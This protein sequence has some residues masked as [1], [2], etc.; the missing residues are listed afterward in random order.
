MWRPRLPEPWR[1]WWWQRLSAPLGRPLPQ[2]RLFVLPTRL[3]IGW[4]ALVGVLTLFGINY[5]NSLAY[6]LAFWLAAVGVVGIWR[7]W[8]NLHGVTVQVQPLGEA[9]AGETVRIK[10][11]LR[12][13][14]PRLA[15]QV[16]L[17]EAQHHVDL[18]DGE[19]QA[20]LDV[21][22][23]RRGRQR[24]A[25]LRV[26]TRW[27]LGLVRI[28]AWLVETPSLLVYP[29]P[30]G[31]GGSHGRDRGVDP[32]ALDFTGLR[33]YQPGDSPAH[34]AWKQ[35]SRTGRLQTKRFSA[36]PS[37]VVWLDYATCQGDVEMRLSTLCAQ[38]LRHH[39]AGDSYALRLPDG[40]VPAAHGTAQRR[41]VL[42]ALALSSSGA[43]R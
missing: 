15:L 11:A 31:D 24:L 18:D 34:L 40:E 28:T 35:W 9:F 13:E 38:V 25:P 22:V 3:G 5:Q 32:E 21:R 30:H 19:T 7:S 1:R 8:R 16:R 4:V 37:A 26:T 43:G 42:T 14:R 10:V 17:G 20:V 29:R 33:R 39:A 2:R 41:R 12:A 27:P 6:A 23:E 36:P